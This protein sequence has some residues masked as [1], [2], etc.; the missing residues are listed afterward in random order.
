MT[1]ILSIAGTV[2]ALWLL[3]SK[4]AV[5]TAIERAICYVQQTHISAL[6][7]HGTRRLTIED[8]QAALTRAVDVAL[9]LLGPFAILALRLYRLRWDLRPWLT[10]R[11]EAQL[12]Q[13]K[14]SELVAMSQDAWQARN[15]GVN[16]AI[17][18]INDLLAQ[19]GLAGMRPYAQTDP[20]QPA[21]PCPIHPGAA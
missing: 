8:K 1:L 3:A 17:G 6:R 19:Y 18:A 20:A 7:A 15:P 13:L 4:R 9:R 10:L 21:A 11:I 14:E 2:I 12:Y 16:L 5:D